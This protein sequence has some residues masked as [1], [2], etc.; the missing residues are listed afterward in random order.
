ML[1]I[2][3]FPIWDLNFRALFLFVVVDFFDF[4]IALYKVNLT[5][6]RKASPEVSLEV[7]VGC[8]LFISGGGRLS[9]GVVV[10]AL[11]G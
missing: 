8:T 7:E 10:H 4:L 3:L 9:D 11:G 1:F 5:V 2:S 6:D